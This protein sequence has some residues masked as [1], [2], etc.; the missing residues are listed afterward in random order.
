MVEIGTVKYL[1]GF[2]WLEN[3]FMCVFCSIKSSCL[4]DQRQLGLGIWSG[5][6][7]VA[8]NKTR[9]RINY[10]TSWRKTTTVWTGAA[11]L[12]ASKVNRVLRR[13]WLLNVIQNDQVDARS[14]VV[15]YPKTRAIRWWVHGAVSHCLGF[16]ACAIFSFFSP[17]A[18][19][20]RLLSQPFVH[21]GF[22]H[23]TKKCG[24]QKRTTATSTPAS[25]TRPPRTNAAKSI[26]GNIAFI[27][28][29][30]FVTFGAVVTFVAI[31]YF[32]FVATSTKLATATTATK[33]YATAVSATA[34][35]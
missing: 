21:L 24:V 4:L 20:S 19:H 23:V 15:S 29:V 2:R 35:R 3:T 10:F 1:G 31:A 12:P 8:H 28:F 33:P 30:T 6:G 22:C 7:P 17:H 16:C 11:I 25:A 34:W 27:A 32:G 26:A 9:P 5:S 14:R 18:L 13:Q